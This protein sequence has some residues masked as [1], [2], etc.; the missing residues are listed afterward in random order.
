MNT[1]G[2]GSG[3]AVA[4]LSWIYLGLAII[5]LGIEIVTENKF[6]RLSIGSILLAILLAIISISYATGWRFAG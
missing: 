5:L 3:I 1:L 4:V 2:R 6:I